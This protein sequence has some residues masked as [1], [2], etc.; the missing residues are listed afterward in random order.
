MQALLGHASLGTTTR[1]TKADAARQFQSVEAFFNTARDGSD[2]L[3][4][5]ATPAP[6]NARRRNGHRWWLCT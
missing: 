1:Y 2:E 6:A 4:T 3:V 5:P